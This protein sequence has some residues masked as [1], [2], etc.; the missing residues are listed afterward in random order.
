MVLYSRSLIEF[1]ELY[2]M[3]KCV[4]LYSVVVNSSNKVNELENRLKEFRF[5]GSIQSIQN[6]GWDYK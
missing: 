6:I 3:K 1:I 5:S 2:L 4:N